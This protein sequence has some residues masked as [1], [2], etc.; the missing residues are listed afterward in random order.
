MI[1]PQV[2][3]PGGGSN[4][5][6]VAVR[7]G[8]A[9]VICV[10]AIRRKAVVVNCVITVR[11]KAGSQYVVSCRNCRW[12]SHAVAVVHCRVAEEHSQYSDN[13]AALLN[14]EPICLLN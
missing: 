9:V 8:A 4:L 12:Q 6:V 3:G 10:I 14:F 7:H 11:L 13:G 1:Y 2:R 5:C